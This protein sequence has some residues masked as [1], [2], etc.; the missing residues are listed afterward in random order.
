MGVD[1]EQRRIVATQVDANARDQGHLLAMLDQV[2]DTLRG[3]A[4][5]RAGRLGR[6]PHQPPHPVPTDRTERQRRP[7]PA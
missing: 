2:S 7:L 4:R 5:G 1:A 3:A 6:L